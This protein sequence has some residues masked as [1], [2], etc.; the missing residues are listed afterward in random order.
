M[1]L[2]NPLRVTAALRRSVSPAEK[3]KMLVTITDR[4]KNWWVK[5]KIITFLA[6]ELENVL[7]DIL[8][9]WSPMKQ[10]RRAGDGVESDVGDLRNFNA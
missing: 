8:L 1:L 5:K 4:N 9:W 3:D 2:C 6:V 10:N 7:D